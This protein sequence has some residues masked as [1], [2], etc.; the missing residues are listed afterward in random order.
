MKIRQKIW[1]VGLTVC[2][3]IGIQ[4]CMQRNN[5]SDGDWIRVNLDLS[6]KNSSQQNEISQNTTSSGVKE[7][8]TVYIA[9][10]LGSVSSVDLTTNLSDALGDALLK[11]DNT[12]TLNLPVGEEIRLVRVFYS[13]VVSLTEINTSS[14]V[15]LS[16]ALSEPFTIDA[17]TERK[18]V[19]IIMP[20]IAYNLTKDSYVNGIYKTSATGS[21]AFD[22]NYWGWHDSDFVMDEDQDQNIYGNANFYYFL[23]NDN[24]TISYMKGIDVPFPWSGGDDRELAKVPF[25]DGSFA[26]TATETGWYRPIKVTEAAP[27][28]ILDNNGNIAAGV[29]YPKFSFTYDPVTGYPTGGTGV[30]WDPSTDAPVTVSAPGM[31]QCPNGPIGTQQEYFFTTTSNFYFFNYFFGGFTTKD[32]SGD[33]LCTWSLNFEGNHTFENGSRTVNE[34]QTKAWYAGDGT[35]LISDPSTDIEGVTGAAKWIMTRSLTGTVWTD[36]VK[37]YDA[38]G[39]EM[40]RNIT[41]VTYASTAQPQASSSTFEEYDVSGDVAT[42]T[43]KQEKTHT[44]GFETG[45][46]DYAVVGGTA[47][48]DSLHTVTADSQGR[49]VFWRATNVAGETI[50]ESEFSFDANGRSTG[51]R[52]YTVSNGTRIPVCNLNRNWDFS[53]ATDTSGNMEVYLESYCDLS[54]GS[55]GTI[56]TTPAYRMINTFNALGQKLLERQYYNL[57]FGPPANMRNMVGSSNQSIMPARIDVKIPGLKIAAGLIKVAKMTALKSGTQDL[58]DQKEIVVNPE[59]VRSTD[60]KPNPFSAS[61]IVDWKIFRQ[62]RWE[63]DT[64]GA[65]TRNDQYDFDAT[66]DA[67][68]LSHYETYE[69]DANLYKTA[70]KKYD[71]EGDLNIQ[72]DNVSWSALKCSL[73][74]TIACYMIRQY[75]Y[76]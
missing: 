40:R 68:I 55:P 6:S 54:S 26:G 4:S 36:T 34:T 52:E 44:R 60:Y 20:T 11:S 62:E 25:A 49:A 19:Q 18:S 75:T 17:D 38:S 74:P 67:M 28:T 2:L 29:S 50:Y 15:P 37:W 61:V 12:I 46:V 72:P 73:N 31:F 21:Q 42:L 71:R 56:Q 16:I 48:V 13:G 35:T 59:P 27:Y 10:V 69:Y 32:A 7:Y 8:P 39:D 24:K 22:S 5:K 45:R 58:S 14:L 23:E 30:Y 41:T 63:Y 70:I 43:S 47:T 57:A 76:E 64:T 51:I 53:Y 66:A 9:A 33:S 3:L 65:R 1:T